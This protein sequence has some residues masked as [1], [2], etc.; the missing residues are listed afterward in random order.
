MRSKNVLKL[1]V[2]LVLI[3]V[4]VIVIGGFAIIKMATWTDV[5][6]KSI[7]FIRDLEDCEPFIGGDN[8]ELREFFNPNKEELDLR[9]SL[10]HAVVKP[11]QTTKPHKLKTSEVYYI[12]EGKGQMHINNEVNQVV[13][14]H[15]VYIPPHSIE[16]IKNIGETDLKF[17]CIV[18]PAWKTEDETIPD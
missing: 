16:Y 17:L 15:A 5:E 13:P 14:G 11:G 10:A 6:K 7:L 8:S 18:D 4:I 9:Y 1:L 2:F 12:L 3:I